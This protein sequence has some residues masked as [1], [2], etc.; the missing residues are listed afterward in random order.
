MALGGVARRAA[1]GLQTP[2]PLSLVLAD[3]AATEALGRRLADCARPGDVI[4]LE[5]PLG[6]GK[7]TLARAFIR[8]LTSPAEDVPSPTFTLVQTYASPRGPIWHFDL[9]RL[10]HPGE[11]I[12]LGLE[13]AFAEGIALIEWPERLGPYL[14][15]RRLDLRLATESE[16]DTRRAILDG[17]AW[18]DRLAALDHD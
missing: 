1:H 9:F 5:G 3:E 13:D 18:Q 15:A 11:A 6:A 7:T 2:M 4:A 12:E 10:G 16:G 17:A 8:H 14:P